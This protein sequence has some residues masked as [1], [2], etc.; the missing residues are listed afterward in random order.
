M[1]VVKPLAEMILR[2]SIAFRLNA[3]LKALNGVALKSKVDSVSIAFRL[4]A[5]LKALNGVALKSK[6]DS[7]SIAFRLNARLKVPVRDQQ[8]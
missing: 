8:S 4:N 2:V 5:R 3:R 7:V 6:V 1:D